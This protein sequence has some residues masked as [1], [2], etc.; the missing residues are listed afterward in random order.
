MKKDKREIKYLRSTFYWALFLLVVSFVQGCGENSVHSDQKVNEHRIPAEHSNLAWNFTTLPEE[1]IQIVDE[2]LGDDYYSG[3]GGGTSLGLSLNNI[4]EVTNLDDWY[5]RIYLETP[6]DELLLTLGNHTNVDRNFV[7]K[8]FYNYEEVDFSVVG[9]EEYSKEFLF[10]LPSANQVEMPIRLDQ[11]L[12][13]SNSISKLTVAVFMAPERFAMQERKLFEDF[14]LGLVLNFEIVYY[15]D[16]ELVLNFPSVEP[17]LRILEAYGI[18]GLGINQEFNPPGYAIYVPENPLMV[19]TGEEIE[20]GFVT[21]STNWNYDQVNVA[22]DYVII[23]LL[24][25][26][27]QPVN[28]QPFLLVN[29]S[30]EPDIGDHG[31]FYI[32]APQDA[33][34]YEMIAFLVPNPTQANSAASFFPLEQSMRFTLVVE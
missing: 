16:S 19:S 26:Q 9:T 31:R 24:D 7:L 5:G 12:T 34:F 2:E 4:E 25:W 28:G 6:Q 32:T 21:N 27:Q 33:G 29:G 17:S 13:T 15:N 22:E 3:Y 1:D 14:N 10:T 30:P 11:N 23:V 20:F 8:L 18:H